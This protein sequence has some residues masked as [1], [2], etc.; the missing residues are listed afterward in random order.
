MKI[1]SI[2][3]SNGFN[4]A[5]FGEAGIS[6]YRLTDRSFNSI[7]I[8]KLYF[9]AHKEFALFV[10]ILSQFNKLKNSANTVETNR[11]GNNIQRRVQ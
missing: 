10:Q 8:N 2:L 11:L 5:N 4:I 7:S 1:R 6:F 3:E 9:L